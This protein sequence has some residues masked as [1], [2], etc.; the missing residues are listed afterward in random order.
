M[1]G[2]ATLRNKKQEED[3]LVL[4]ILS[5]DCHRSEATQAAM[6]LNNRTSSVMNLRPGLEISI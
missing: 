5:L 2:N 3:E 4:H 1:E 6:S